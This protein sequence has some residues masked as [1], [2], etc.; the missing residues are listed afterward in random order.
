MVYPD[1]KLLIFN[2]D[3]F[4]TITKCSIVCTKLWFIW[5]NYKNS[6]PPMVIPQPLTTPLTVP[7][8]N[9]T[10]GKHI[11]FTLSSKTNGESNFRIAKS[12]STF[13]T[14]INLSN[15]S[16][17]LLAQG[18]IIISEM[19]LVCPVVSPWVSFSSCQQ[20]LTKKF[21]IEGMQGRHRCGARA[22]AR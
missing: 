2:F 21:Q 6:V 9:E 12:T 10:S 17:F 18:C 19:P 1:P 14:F 11:G 20:N 15:F 13:F 8:S 4:L 22:Q 7:G 3:I 16:L 5:N